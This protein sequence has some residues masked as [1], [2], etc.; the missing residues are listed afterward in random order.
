M[1]V[2]TAS[3]MFRRRRGEVNCEAT[4]VSI[5]QFMEDTKTR[6]EMMMVTTHLFGICLFTALIISTPKT[7]VRGPFTKISDAFLGLK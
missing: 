5:R 3:T 7:M 6:L 2:V 1:P 4:L